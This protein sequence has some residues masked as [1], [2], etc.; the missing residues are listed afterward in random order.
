MEDELREED[1]ATSRAARRAS[2]VGRLPGPRSARPRPRLGWLGR[3]ANSGEE[4]AQN[5]VSVDELLS[6]IHELRNQV[7]NARN[8]AN[9]ARSR[10]R[11]EQDVNRR[12]HQTIKEIES[13]RDSMSLGVK[14][15]EAQ[16]RQV[17]AL[18][19]EGIG[20]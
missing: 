8:E 4:A 7:R 6:Q 16:I 14:K 20:A 12:L 15:Q 11:A 17:Q 18:A 13:E 1:V 9:E 19:F 2:P 3:L 10:V 5:E